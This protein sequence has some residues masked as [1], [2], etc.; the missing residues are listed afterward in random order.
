M[1][2]VYLSYANITPSYLNNVELN[3]GK[4]SLIAQL[5]CC[6]DFYFRL[7]PYDNSQ[8]IKP[9]EEYTSCNTG[10]HLTRHH[11][12]CCCEKF[13]EIRS[14]YLAEVVNISQ[15]AFLEL[16]KNPSLIF[17]N[18]IYYFLLSYFRFNSTKVLLQL[19]GA[20]IAPSVIWKIPPRNIQLLRAGPKVVVLRRAV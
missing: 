6:P 9:S 10:S 14:K 2:I 16:I 19:A 17:M 7:K 1:K 8:V 11:I 3:S 12:I 20:F 5:R 4:I 13:S 18:G 15:Y